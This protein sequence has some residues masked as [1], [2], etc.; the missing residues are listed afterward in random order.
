MSLRSIL[1]ALAVLLAATLSPAAAIDDASATIGRGLNLGNALEAPRE[2]EWGYTIKATDFDTIKSAGFTNV[3]IPI[4]W[5]Y[6]AAPKPPYQIDPKFFSR[7]DEIVDA[8]LDRGLV[9]ILND[10]HEN[11]LCKDPAAH[12]ERFIAQWRQIAQHF[13]HRPASLYFEL[14]NE[15]HGKLDD[16]AWN[17]LLLGALAEV[18]K[19]NPTR[20]VVIGPANYNTIS[21]L[22]KLKLPRDDRNLIVTVHYYEPFNFTHQGAEWTGPEATKWLGTKWEGTDA[23]K[24]AVEKHLAAAARWGGENN[25]PVYLGEF[26]AY[27][28]GAM[29][30]RARWTDFVARTAEKNHMSWSYWEYCAGFGVY[31]PK[32]KEY[33]PELLRALLPK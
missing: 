27:S 2:G 10:H 16:G 31:D 11:E 20:P 13:S 7:V 21:K 23:E 24:A 17:E 5:A 29:E 28:K 25:R 8:A 6:Y 3:R 19:A 26:G 1:S 32:A 12:R 9:V 15:P 4:S 14:L 22:E 33:R 30:S 18:R